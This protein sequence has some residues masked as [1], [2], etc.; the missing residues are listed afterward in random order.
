MDL[1]TEQAALLAAIVGWPRA[2]ASVAEL[3]AAG[4]AGETLEELV[5]LDLVEHWGRPHVGEL[6][7]DLVTLTPWGM[8][9]CRVRIDERFEWLETEDGGK[10]LAE[11][12]HYAELG[13]PEWPIHLP[14]AGREHPLPFPERVVDPGPRP[15]DLAD[16]DDGPEFLV[17]QWTGRPI[18]LF[19]GED[20]EGVP[21]VREKRTHRG[22]KARELACA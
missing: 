3:A 7:E 18:T 4:H 16:V 8:A 6:P 5:A 22:R 10:A 1:T 14:Q 2:W 19:A 21:V 13:A 9:V 17:D 11:T 15:E 20:G 12:P